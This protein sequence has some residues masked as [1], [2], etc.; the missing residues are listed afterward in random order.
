V[1]NGVKRFITGADKSDFMILMAAT[2][3]SKGSHGGI[4]C[5][6]VDMNTPG[7]TL[8]TSYETITGE[9]PWEI[10]FDNVRV[11]VEHLVGEEGGGFKLGQ[12]WLGVGRVK[13]GARALGATRRSRSAR[14]RSG[15]SRI[16]TSR[17]RLRPSSSTAPPRSSTEARTTGTTPTS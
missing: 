8:S 5:F 11:S 12:G 7:V 6:I 14:T 9:R 3:R 10:V 17:S 2:D 13:Q 15:S 16:P 4:S 1:I